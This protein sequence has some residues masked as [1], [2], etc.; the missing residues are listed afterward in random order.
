MFNLT[1]TEH[2]TGFICSLAS[3]ASFHFGDLWFLLSVKALN[4]NTALCHTAANRTFFLL[5]PS[6]CVCV[7]QVQLCT[8]YILVVIMK[9][10]VIG[11]SYCHH[12]PLKPL[13]EGTVKWLLMLSHISVCCAMRTQTAF[14]LLEMQTFPDCFTVKFYQALLTCHS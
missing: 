14:I 2:C 8:E 12:M 11:P 3:A 1:S 7:C 9:F 10:E 4:K 13:S 5:S 6:V